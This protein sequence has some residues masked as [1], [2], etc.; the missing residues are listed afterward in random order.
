MNDHPAIESHWHWEFYAY[1]GPVVEQGSI[2]W[3]VMIRVTG[4]ENEAD[5]MIAAHAILRRDNFVLRSVWD[6]AQ[7]GYQNKIAGTMASMAK[8]MG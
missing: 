4:Y 1:D 2:H 3:P 8:A 7:C 6:C 5:A